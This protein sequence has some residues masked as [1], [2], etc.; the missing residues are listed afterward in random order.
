MIEN[1]LDLENGVLEN[2]TDRVVRKASNMR[3]FYN[4]EEALEALISNGDP[5]IYDVYAVVKEGEGELCYAITILHAGKVGDEYFMTKG[6]YHEKKDRAELYIGLRGQGL[7]LMQKGDE[8]KWVEMRRGTVVYVPP[9]WAHR[10]VNTGSGDFVFLAI[11]P[12]DAGHDYGSIAERGF[13]KIVV[14]RDGRYE[15]I[16]NPRYR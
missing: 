10:S 1:Y 8:V 5:T 16:D 13:A 3:G 15:V 14:E 6:H 11:Y 9:Y 4:D 7:L 12:G 2:Y